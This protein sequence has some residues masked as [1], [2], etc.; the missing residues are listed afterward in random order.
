[1]EKIPNKI[2]HQELEKKRIL[3]LLNG[4]AVRSEN[5][6]FAH[7]PLVTE[8][9]ANVGTEMKG[10]VSGGAARMRAIQSEFTKAERKGTSENL[11]VLTFGTFEPKKEET[12]SE[13]SRPEEAGL[14]LQERYG[15]PADAVEAHTTAGSTRNASAAAAEYVYTHRKELGDINE[16]EIV[17]NDFHMLRSWIMH[18]NAF[19][20]EAAQEELRDIIPEEDKEKIYAVLDTYSPNEE[21]W[22]PTDIKVARDAVMQIIKKNLPENIITIKPLIVEE[23]LE[24]YSLTENDAGSEARA[25][26]A[27]L[28]RNNEYVRETLQ[29]EYRGIKNFLSGTYRTQ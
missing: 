18:T 2:E 11:K 17:T 1:M 10:E 5:L 27:S 19:L 8:D 22:V 4:R 25:R 21:T 28:L 15:L 24:D 16:V 14:Q 12:D 23:A 26:Y 20:K 29:F 6:E 13:L 7:F 9:Q 3:I